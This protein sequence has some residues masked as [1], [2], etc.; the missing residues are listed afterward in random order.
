MDTSSHHPRV[1]ARRSGGAFH[2]RDI[3][4]ILLS[5][6]RADYR[7]G[8]RTFHKRTRPGGRRSGG[9]D[10]TDARRTGQKRRLHQIHESDV[11]QPG[12]PYLGQDALRLFQIPHP[13]RICVRIS[14]G[15]LY[16]VRIRSNRP[17]RTVSVHTCQG[18][19]QYRKTHRP[20]EIRDR[21]R[22]G[23]IF[24]KVSEGPERDVAQR[25]SVQRSFH[26]I[27][28]A[29][30]Q[31]GKALHRFLQPHLHIRPGITVLRIRSGPER[32]HGDRTQTGHDRL[33]RQGA[34]PEI[35]QLHGLPSDIRRQ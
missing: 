19:V 32:G 5:V 6:R 10:R 26:R 8:T 17:D 23:G 9:G 28:R 11:H 21:D 14:A 30:V 18:L 13:G 7:P 20:S 24:P 29:G 1:Q 2:K 3:Q 34:F 15:K 4:C 16:P 31:K 35:L 27:H 33:L 12:L 22:Q 25:L